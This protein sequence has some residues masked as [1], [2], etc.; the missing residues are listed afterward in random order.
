MK[1]STFSIILFLSAVLL[2]GCPY[3][4]EVPLGKA[5]IKVDNTIIK[6]WKQGSSSDYT[7]KVLKNDEFTYKIEKKSKSSGDITT[8][9]GFIN[10]ID[11][12]KYM[13]VYEDGSTSKT[14]YFYKYE[15]VS[16]DKL[17]LTPVTENIDER[18]TSSS[19]LAAFFK[20]NQKNSY[21]F[22]NSEDE[23]TPAD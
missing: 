7:Y 8:Y 14:Y 15:Q 21:F 19:E 3:S 2:M 18:F 12:T 5:D 20:K 22:D 4:A 16:S 10:D 9:I 11:G 1:N 6:T 13:S 23:Y 17:V